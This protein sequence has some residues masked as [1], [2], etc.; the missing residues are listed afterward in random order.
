MNLLLPHEI[1]RNEKKLFYNFKDKKLIL[2]DLNF[3]M[4]G[5]RTWISMDA[6]PPHW[7]VAHETTLC[8]ITQ[9]LFRIFY[10]V[11]A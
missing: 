7:F 3:N 9:N 11:T 5:K 2:K 10:E 6:Q 8:K 4:H 1:Y